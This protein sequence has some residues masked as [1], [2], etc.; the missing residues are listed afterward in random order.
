MHAVAVWH[1]NIV[2][3]QFRFLSSSNRNN[4][5]FLSLSRAVKPTLGAATF[6]LHFSSFV[7]MLIFVM[8]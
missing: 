4:G 6:F 1:T 7:W 3:A 2:L 8:L 5:T